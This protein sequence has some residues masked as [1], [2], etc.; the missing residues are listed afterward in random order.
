ME[1]DAALASCLASGISAEDRDY[2]RFHAERF[3]EVISL[4]HSHSRPGSR[5]A[6]VGLSCFDLIAV[7]V[8]ADRHYVSLV[9]TQEF[10][11]K[12][13]ESLYGKVPKIVYDV[14]RDVSS[15]DQGYD[16]MILADVLEHLLC[17]DE[18]VVDR[19][20]RAL[21][22]EGVAI[23]SFPNAMRHVN[24]ARALLGRNV[25]PAKGD[26]V[27]GVFGGYG[28]IREYSM[29]EVSDLLKPRF[30]HIRVKG[31]SAYGSSA[32][33]RALKLL[34]HSMQSTILAVASV[35]KP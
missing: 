10:A 13:P 29:R 27:H 25:F 26:I 23:F 5:I 8:L 4:T 24:R 31:L 30:E 22:P 15:P 33:R 7:D 20:R 12:F 1:F 9:P 35:P 21:A 34:P 14:T 18:P 2:V 17:E 19:V 6:N 3:R 11:S 32:Q 16:V 28:H